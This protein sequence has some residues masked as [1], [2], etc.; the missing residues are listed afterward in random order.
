MKLDELRARLRTQE[1]KRAEPIAQRCLDCKRTHG[2]D[3]RLLQIKAIKN[4][5]VEGDVLLCEYCIHMREPPIGVLRCQDC[6][7]AFDD[8]GAPLRIAA[9]K[10]VY[11]G[12]R[13]ALCDDCASL[14]KRPFRKAP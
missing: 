9:T 12:A 6:K 7:R 1:L 14:H 4:K 5:H 13:L 10:S 11:A 2:E 8:D 3:G